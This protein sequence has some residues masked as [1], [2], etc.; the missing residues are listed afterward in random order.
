MDD[1]WITKLNLNESDRSESWRVTPFSWCQ[2]VLQGWVRVEKLAHCPPLWLAEGVSK[3]QLSWTR[4]HYSL[5]IAIWPF[6]SAWRHVHVSPPFKV[7]WIKND[8]HSVLQGSFCVCAQPLAGRIHKLTPGAD[9]RSLLRQSASRP[10][11][12]DFVLSGESSW[13]MAALRDD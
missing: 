3:I 11:C 4:N 8:L 10:A 2:S 13:R 7:I 1:F 9:L 12:L 6:A 5:I